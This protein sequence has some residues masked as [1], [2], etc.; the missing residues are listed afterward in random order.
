VCDDDEQMSAIIGVNAFAGIKLQECQ[1][2][3]RSRLCV[4]VTRNRPARPARPEGGSSSPDNLPA[5]WSRAHTTPPHQLLHIRRETD[6]GSGGGVVAGR[7][8]SLFCFLL[9]SPTEYT[10]SYLYTY[11]GTHTRLDIYTREMQIY[12]G[13]RIYTFICSN[14]RKCTQIYADIHSDMGIERYQHIQIQIH[15]NAHIYTH[16]HTNIYAN[17][18]KPL[19]MHTRTHT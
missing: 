15:T 8:R 17:I 13:L 19:Q 12:H 2:E 6:C 11:S 10:Y 7:D 16:I 9:P 5:P 4:S 18:R 3:R 14:T 1:D